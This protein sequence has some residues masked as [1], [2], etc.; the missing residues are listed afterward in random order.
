M[1]IKAAA[2]RRP[3]SQFTYLTRRASGEEFIRK[4]K[5]H[6]NAEQSKEPRLI[7]DGAVNNDRDQNRANKMGA[8][9]GYIWIA[10]IYV[11]ELVGYPYRR[12][13]RAFVMSFPIKLFRSS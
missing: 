8:V 5:F 12:R 11:T 6:D 2:A 3:I 1:E 7:A 9:P 10:P 13:T 4:R